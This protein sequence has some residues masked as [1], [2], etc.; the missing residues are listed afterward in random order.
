[1]VRFALAELQRDGLVEA[2]DTGPA[3]SRR[4]MLQSLGV[5]GA[6]LLPAVAAIVAPAAADAQSGCFDCGSD[7]A[8][9][10]GQAA[11]ARRL[12]QLNNAQPPP[13]GAPQK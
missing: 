12:Q 4:A 1:M 6:L 13:A 8:P 9:S 2:V 10:S 7:V 5:G 3:I 11:R